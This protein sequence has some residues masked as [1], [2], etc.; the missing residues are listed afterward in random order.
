MAPAMEACCLSLATPL[1]A[2]KAAPPFEVCR[3]IGD[4]ESR[5]A[6]RAAT[7]VEDEVTLIAGMAK[8]FSL[9][10][11]NL[12]LLDG[13]PVSAKM[14]RLEAHGEQLVDILAVDDADGEL[15]V[16]QNAHGDGL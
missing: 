4:L 12:V 5:A 1:P 3:I 11:Y 2:K 10:Y 7:T 8:P 14:K 15:E 13:W 6:S 9:A 16:V